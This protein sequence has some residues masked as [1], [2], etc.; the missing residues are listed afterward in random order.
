MQLSA[1]RSSWHSA[2]YGTIKKEVVPFDVKQKHSLKGYERVFDIL[3]H[4]L[5]P[6]PVAMFEENGGQPH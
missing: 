6:Y 3:G 4:E 5:S 2:F 1:Y